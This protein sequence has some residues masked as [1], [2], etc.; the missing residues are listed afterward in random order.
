MWAIS[1]WAG[2]R[3]RSTLNRLAGVNVPPSNDH[4]V[5]HTEGTVKK[6]MGGVIVP[7][8]NLTSG[9]DLDQDRMA[10][11]L[12]RAFGIKVGFQYDLFGSPTGKKLDDM[13]SDINEYNLDEWAKIISN[14][15][16]PV[17]STP[18]SPIIYAH[19]LQRH[20]CAM[21]SSKL[22]TMLGYEFIHPRFGVESIRDTIGFWKKEGIWPN[23]DRYP[24]H[25]GYDGK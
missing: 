6:S 5:E 12:A 7:V 24:P 19:E 18:L 9:E 3:D 20:G 14:A 2:E 11:A 1:T 15:N 4:L 8:F 23:T 16:P 13:F 22:R 25:N 21:D 17:I 10:N